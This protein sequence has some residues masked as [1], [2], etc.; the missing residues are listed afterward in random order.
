[1]SIQQQ[2]GVSLKFEARDLCRSYRLS[3]SR[4]HAVLSKVNFLI[5]PG[6]FTVIL[7]ESGSGKSTLLNLLSGLIMPTSGQILIDSQPIIGPSPDRSLLFQQPNLLP[8][9]SVADNIVFGCRLRGERDKIE[10]R[11]L[12]LIQMIGLVGYEDRHPVELSVGMAQRVCLAR[13]LI[14]QPKALLLDEPFGALDIFNRV[15]LQNE[16]INLWQQR[17]FTGILVTHDIDEALVVAQKI[18]ILGGQPATAQSVYN[19]TLPYPRDISSFPFFEARSQVLQ[20]LRAATTDTDSL[21]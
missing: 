18:I 7:G 11:L 10:D 4:S 1:L 8:W 15:R 14:G 12:Q 19:V 21:C 16:L 2:I 17:P 5:E 13:A 9:L 6:C 3:R 20:L